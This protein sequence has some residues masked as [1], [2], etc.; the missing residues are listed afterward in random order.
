MSY[1]SEKSKETEV[2]QAAIMKWGKEL[3]IEIAIEECAELIKALQKLKRCSDDTILGPRRNVHEEIA[4]VEIMIEQLKL[5][6]NRQLIEEYKIEKIER[7]K[8]RLL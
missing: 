7:L 2:Y 4:D 1:I 6:F 3:Q 8:S 5:I